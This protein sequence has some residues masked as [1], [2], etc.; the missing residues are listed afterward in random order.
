MTPPLKADA[1][2]T[3]AFFVRMLT[4]DIALDDCIFDL[5][6]NSLDGAWE[7]TGTNPSEITVD[8]KLEAFSIDITIS[9]DLFKITDN[10]GGISLVEAQN[11]AF[12]FGRKDDEP[13]SQYSVGVYGIGMKRAVFKIGTSISIDSTYE[14]EGR[15]AGFRVPIDVNE[16]TQDET[17]DWD[18][19]IEETPA[20][21]SAGV[22]IE[23]RN[24]TEE[25]RQKFADPTFVRSLRQSLGRDY[26]LPLQRGLTIT[27][28]GDP[29]I[30]Q[31][32]V[33][34]E[35]EEFGAMRHKYEEDGV[36][37][38]IVA[39][40]VSPPP[41][42]ADP[43]TQARPDQLSGVYVVCNGRVVL[44]A[45]RTSVTGWGSTWRQQWHGQYSGFV[46]MMLF[47]AEDAAKLPMTTTK[48]SVD[49]SSAVYAR[50]LV[51]LANPVGDW[52]TYTNQRKSERE[53]AKASEQQS[54]P[55]PLANVRPREKVQLPNLSQGKPRVRPAN[56]NYSV[57]LKRLKALA[58]AM[59]SINLTY[60]E[61]GIKSFDFAYENLV[62][63]ED[64]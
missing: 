12:T 56:I 44:A 25:T 27:L 36:T 31:R 13:T 11:Y 57:P 10:C 37:V 9:P 39:G 22:T 55:T 35:S 2:P 54:K 3:K 38:E 17:E 63:E 21:S 24:L 64:E 50:A 34:L 48:R 19:S 46:A 58:D 42:D 30:G 47:S 5:L 23:V 51:Q 7:S 20:G 6:D 53:R 8:T 43:E 59:G 33:L 14:T 52:I 45:D 32:I 41:D 4:R 49:A 29:V 61:V 16:W 28:N 18:F 26:L 1:S 15:L 60:R 40:M 62:G